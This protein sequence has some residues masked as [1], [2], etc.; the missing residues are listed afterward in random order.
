VPPKISKSA[1]A[2]HLNSAD[3]IPFHSM[4]TKGFISDPE[5]D[6]RLTCSARAREGPPNRTACCFSGIVH[7][8]C[9]PQGITCGGERLHITRHYSKQMVP[10]FRRQ[11]A[12][13]E[14]YP[15]LPGLK[16]GF[17]VPQAGVT[18]NRGTEPAMRDFEELVFPE[19]RGDRSSRSIRKYLYLLMTNLQSGGLD[20]GAGVS[21]PFG[22]T[23]PAGRGKTRPY[24]PADSPM[25]P[26]SR[27]L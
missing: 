27:Y 23:K 19:R 10:P 8:E 1:T 25:V 21:P 18:V 11:D 17:V 15:G 24:Q 12:F 7:R 5:V 2:A 26:M 3:L 14:P 9:R 4:A 16:S 20:V 6:P 13:T 22:L